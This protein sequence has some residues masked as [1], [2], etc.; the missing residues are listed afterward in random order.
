M[1][2]VESRVRE[3][4]REDID[5]LSVDGV[6]DDVR[7]GA[8]RRRARRTTLVAAAAAL[9]LTAAGGGL[10]WHRQSAPVT[11]RPESAL[12]TG[13]VTVSVDA[14]G[15]AYEVVANE[16]CDTPCSTIRVSDGSGG[17][18]SLASIRDASSHARPYG[19]VTTLEMAPNGHDGWA[20]GTHLW[21]THDGG[22]TWAR[23]MSPP[24]ALSPDD[25]NLDISPGP[26]VTWAL[27]SPR[28]APQLWRTPTGS[29]TWTRVS[30]PR[31][32]GQAIAT[33][34]PDSRIALP[35]VKGVDEFK[36]VRRPGR[37]IRL[38]ERYDVGDGIGPWRR[39]MV[40]CLTTRLPFKE[41]PKAQVCGPGGHRE[42]GGEIMGPR[43]PAGVQRFKDLLIEVGTTGPEGDNPLGHEKTLDVTPWRAVLA[44]PHGSIPV[45]LHLPTFMGADA[46][47]VWG[48]HVVFLSGDHRIYASDDGGRHWHEE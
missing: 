13:P 22:Q 35:V 23:V 8:R 19:P 1:S 48:S 3:A 21:S 40:P 39:V 9:V 37:P 5:R 15:T 11:H 12:E 38:I 17:W 28:H 2:T 20:W 16:G 34:L 30:L 45:R 18:S 10:V 32:T 41:V 6:L 26:Q 24:G 14:S 46:T 44:R 4:L 43:R 36:R 42:G 31:G 47:A 25:S 7:R 29:D 27:L 33:V